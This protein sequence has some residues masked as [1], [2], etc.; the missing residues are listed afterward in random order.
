MDQILLISI[1]SITVIQ[2]IYWFLFLIVHLSNKKYTST[3][4]NEPVS[5]IV[6][7]HNELGNLK[8]LIPNLLHQKH[9]DFEVIIVNDRSDDGSYDYLNEEKEKF[10]NLKVVNIDK[11]HDHISPKKYAITL[12]VKAAKN[13]VLLFTDADC[14]PSSEY[15]IAKMSVIDYSDDFAIGYSPY[16]KQDGLLNAFIRFETRLT[17]ILYTSFALLGNPCMGVGRN[18]LYRKS[19]FMKQNGFNKFQNVIGGDDDL[20]VNQFATRKNTKVVLGHDCLTISIPKTSWSTYFTQKKRHISVGKF[21]KFNDRFLLGVYSMTH[22]LFWITLLVMLPLGLFP[23]LTIFLLIIRIL[24]LTSVVALTSK[25]FG[26]VINIWTIPALDFIYS[27]YLIIAG[28]IALFTKKVTW[29]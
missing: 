1:I 18:M 12:G 2:F 24:M 19:L 16:Q 14:I 9:D 8:K 20:F 26:E 13:D 21:Y 11:V 29:K 28:V 4:N 15:W 3:H 23:E 17:G 6:C 7:A 27:F 22:L 10:S 5:V 25:K